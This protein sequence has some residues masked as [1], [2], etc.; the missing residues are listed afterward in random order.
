MNRQDVLAEASCLIDG[1]REERYGDFEENHERIG[2]I[3]GAI[4]GTE[5]IPSHLV[6]LCMVGVKLSR[7]TVTPEHQ[8]NYVDAIAYLAGAA[9]IVTRSE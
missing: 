3:W 1:P 9:E 2:I 7:A 6:A 4:L 5:P 8:D